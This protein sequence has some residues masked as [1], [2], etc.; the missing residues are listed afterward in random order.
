MRVSESP[1]LFAKPDDRWEVNDVAGRCRDVVSKLVSVF[2]QYAQLIE[3]G[4]ADDLPPLEDV[5]LDGLE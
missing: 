2:P 1:E 5:L 4:S 3:S